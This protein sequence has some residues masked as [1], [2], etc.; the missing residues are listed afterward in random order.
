MVNIGNK[1]TGI[2]EESTAMSEIMRTPLKLCTSQ[3]LFLERAGLFF[4]LFF[5]LGSFS[6]AQTCDMG[7]DIDPAIRTS[8]QQ[9]AQKFF[10]MATKD[11]SAGLQQN[12]I[13][14][15]QSDFSGIQYVLTDNKANLSG[16]TATAQGTYLLTNPSAAPGGRAE[17]FCGIFNSPDRVSFVIPNLAAGKYAIV[18]LDVTGGKSPMKLTFVMHRGRGNWEGFIPGRARSPDTIRNGFSRRPSNT[19]RKA[20]TITPGTTT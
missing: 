9:A 20:K 17:F 18:I 7:D 10:Q 11:D 12:A 5:S 8:A 16:A 4:L 19:N 3:A 13:P 6:Y 1:N 15:L 14:S 2:L